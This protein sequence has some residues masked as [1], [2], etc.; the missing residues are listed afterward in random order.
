MLDPLRGER[1]NK[2]RENENDFFSG[3]DE[4]QEW[5]FWRERTRKNIRNKF[6]R[7]REGGEREGKQKMNL[8]RESDNMKRWWGSD[9]TQV[10][11]GRKWKNRNEF[12][13]WVMETTTTN[14]CRGTEKTESDSLWRENDNQNE[15]LEGESETKNEFSGSVRDGK[16]I[17]EFC[18]WERQNI[19]WE[20]RKEVFGKGEGKREER[21]KERRGGERE[22]WE[23][24]CKKEWKSENRMIWRIRDSAMW[25]S[26]RV[27]ES[28]KRETEWE[29][30]SEKVRQSGW[31]RGR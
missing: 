29:R 3:R 21:G 24:K 30:V 25:K 8:W 6:S 19:T 1:K 23:R 2:N 11:L 28:E 14:F 26:Y 15:F 20:H 27:N 18:S 7:E 31:E 9:N 16:T 13:E 17:N 12:G 22:E 10:N 5:I 4:D